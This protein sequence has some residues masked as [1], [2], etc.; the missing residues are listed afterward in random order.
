[1]GPSSSGHARRRQVVLERRGDLVPA[2]LFGVVD[3]PERRGRVER[4]VG[5]GLGDE[6]LGLRPG[7][8]RTVQARVV[9][10]EAGGIQSSC[11]R[12]PRTPSRAASCGRTRSRSPGGRARRPPAG[13]C[14][15]YWR[16]WTPIPGICSTLMPSTPSSTSKSLGS[17]SKAMSSS[18]L[19]SCAAAVSGLT[20][21]PE[22]DLGDVRRALVV[23]GVRRRT[24]CTGRA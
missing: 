23:V 6:L 7:R 4:A 14:T 19:W 8:T 1:M 16:I 17:M 24:R 15:G 20:F 10:V 3:D 22:D 2:R 5:V 12:R 13:W 21:E 11:A 9:R 18:P